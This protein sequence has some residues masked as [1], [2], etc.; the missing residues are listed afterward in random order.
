MWAAL[1]QF[2]LLKNDSDW[3]RFNLALCFIAFIVSLLWP[4]FV[5]F[6][7][8]R[9]NTYK[10]STEFMYKYEDIYFLKMESISENKFKYYSY[11]LL[12]FLR[13]FVIVLFINAFTDHQ[14]VAPVILIF[15]NIIEIIYVVSLRIFYS[16]VL[17]AVLKV[18][19]NLLFIAIEVSL[20]FV[21]GLSNNARDSDF[22]NLGYALNVLY[23]IVIM[24]ALLKIGYY[25]YHKFRN[26]G[27]NMKFGID[28][29]ETMEVKA[30]PLPH[31]ERN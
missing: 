25:G 23:V 2:H 18:T 16:S 5:V 21:Y 29:G 3:E 13:Y 10:Y 11:V 7:T 20:L 8:Y 12:R 28:N 31:S 26:M 24:V 9:M 14:I 4:I 6:F 22:L 17:G 30:T 1:T 15:A 19:E 27:Y